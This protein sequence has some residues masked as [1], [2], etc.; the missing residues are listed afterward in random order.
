MEFNFSTGLYYRAHPWIEPGLE[1]Y[2]KFGELRDFKPYDDQQHVLFPTIDLIY[3][4]RYRLH[5]GIGIG[6]TEA[7]DDLI[8]KAIFSVEFI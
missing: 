3:K 6:L 5:T 8:W 7:S 1:Y 2:S 4:M